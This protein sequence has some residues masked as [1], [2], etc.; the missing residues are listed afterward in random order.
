MLGGSPVQGRRLRPTDAFRHSPLGPALT[1]GEPQA[2]QGSALCASPWPVSAPN[3]ACCFDPTSSYPFH[4]VY[5]KEEILSGK[6]PQ[7]F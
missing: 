2:S 7:D 5:E 4:L 3:Q 1:L 6:G